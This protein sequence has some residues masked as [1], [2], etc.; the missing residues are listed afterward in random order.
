[1]YKPGHLLELRAVGND[2]ADLEG[3]VPRQAWR[4]YPGPVQP[5]GQSVLKFVSRLCRLVQN[6]VV[7]GLVKVP[8]CLQV[9]G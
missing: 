7:R 6:L 5:D 2:T 4:I 8:A 1:M 3:Q 9:R